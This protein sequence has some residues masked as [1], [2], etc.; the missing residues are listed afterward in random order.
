MEYILLAYS[1]TWKSEFLRVKL[2]LQ[3]FPVMCVSVCKC[4]PDGNYII[5]LI[6]KYIYLCPKHKEK[7][8]IGKIDKTPFITF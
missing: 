8:N 3:N 4:F 2:F 6:L 5:M 1:I 7:I